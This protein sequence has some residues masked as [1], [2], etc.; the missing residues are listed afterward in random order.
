MEKKSDNQVNFL[1]LRQS[2]SWYTITLLI[3]GRPLVF[4][5]GDSSICW[6]QRYN[7]TNSL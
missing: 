7:T 2:L 4:Y 6:N 5:K 1:L 3:L